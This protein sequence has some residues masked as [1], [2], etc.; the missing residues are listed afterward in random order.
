MHFKVQYWFVV[1]RVYENT[2][3]CACYSVAIFFNCFFFWSYFAKLR[4]TI[5]L[6]FLMVEKCPCVNIT[7]HSFKIFYIYLY[8]HMYRHRAAGFGSTAWCNSSRRSAEF[9][10]KHGK[11]IGCCYK[12][13]NGLLGYTYACGIYFIGHKQKKNRC[14]SATNKTISV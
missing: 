10:R 1:L 3:R 4:R 9:L 5:F 8:T 11:H 2:T 14:P 12:Q 6:R 7:V 13:L